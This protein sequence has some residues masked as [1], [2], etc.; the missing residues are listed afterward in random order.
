MRDSVFGAPS[1]NNIRR[2]AMYVH[3]QMG[4]ID[5]VYFPVMR[6]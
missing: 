6:F 3:K 5:T 4:C 1:R 2:M